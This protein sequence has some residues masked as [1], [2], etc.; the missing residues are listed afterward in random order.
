LSLMSFYVGDSR[1]CARMECS[2]IASTIAPQSYRILFSPS[3]VFFFSYTLT[4]SDPATSSKKRARH[5]PLPCTPVILQHESLRHSRRSAHATQS[6]GLA[7]PP[8]Q[9]GGRPR[10]FAIPGRHSG[11][12]R[13]T[14]E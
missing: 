14:N 5:D 8:G 7:R 1:F 2:T 12:G 9:N 6:D 11:R 4:L 13:R 3:P 10:V